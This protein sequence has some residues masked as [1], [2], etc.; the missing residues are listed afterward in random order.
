M[1][2]ANDAVSCGEVACKYIPSGLTG[3]D[4]RMLALLARLTMRLVIAL[5]RCFFVAI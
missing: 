4:E 2:S 1:S 5:V 3:I